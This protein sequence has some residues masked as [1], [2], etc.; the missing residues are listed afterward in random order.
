M[1]RHP[2]SFE[3]ANHI[4]SNFQYLVGKRLNSGRTVSKIDSVVVAPFDDVNKYIF[5]L[6]FRNRRDA[7]EA[8]KMYD[9]NDY[10]VIVIG[11][12]HGESTEYICKDLESYLAETN[13]RSRQ[14]EN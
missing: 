14:S 11:V 6:E 2:L 13:I 3:E 7:P 4:C 10:D 5:M 9:G 8:L 1:A 12:V